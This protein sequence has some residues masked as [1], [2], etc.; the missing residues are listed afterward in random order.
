MTRR[1]LTGSIVTLAA[2]LLVVATGAQANGEPKNQAP[3][4]AGAAQS[5]SAPDWIE[6]YAAAHPY[7]RNLNQPA[8][9]AIA[10]EPKNELPFTKPEG[11]SIPAP[12]SFERYAAA[13]PYGTDVTASAGTRPP[14]GGFHWGDALIGAAATGS[15]VLL[16]AAALGVSRARRRDEFVHAIGA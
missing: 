1:Q 15:L 14:A 16:S 8:P 13:H 6:R 5:N 12:D 7:G 3:F 2:A 4:T 9:S 11:R 10:G